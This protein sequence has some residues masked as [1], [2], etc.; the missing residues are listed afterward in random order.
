MNKVRRILSLVLIAVMMCSALCTNAG[1]YSDCAH[2]REEEYMVAGNVFDENGKCIQQGYFVRVCLDCETQLTEPDGTIQRVESEHQFKDGKCEVCGYTTAC[3]HTNSD[4]SFTGN[5]STTDDGVW[6]KGYFIKYCNDCG[7]EISERK[8]DERLTKHQFD[9]NGKCKKC[10]YVVK[11]EERAAWVYNTDGQN[12]YLREK[13]ATG[14]TKVLARM[15]EGSQITVIGKSKTNGFYKVRY[16]NITGYAHSDYITF[17]KQTKQTTTSK[18]IFG[19]PFKGTARITVLEYYY[20][21]KSGGVHPT[22]GLGGIRGAIDFAVAGSAL[23]TKSGTVVEAKNGYNG[24]WG[25][26]IV[27]RHTDGGTYSFYAHLAKI[28]VSVNQKVKQGQAIGIIGSTGQ[29][30]GTHLHFEVWQSN[31]QTMY[32]IDLFKNCKDRLRFDADIVSG[33]ANST[34]IRNWIKSNYKLSGGVYVPKTSTSSSSKTTTTSSSKQTTTQS[35][36]A[37]NK[38]VSFV[39]ANLTAW[40]GALD[41]KFQAAN[42]V[43]EVVN[44]VNIRSGIQKVLGTGIVAAWTVSPSLLFKAFDE[45]V[46]IGIAS[47][48]VTNEY[49]TRANVAHNSFLALVNKGIK[50]AAQAEK[51][52]ELYKESIAC[53]SAVIDA[54]YSTIC[55]YTKGSTYTKKML[56][57]FFLSVADTVI[58]DLG[59]LTKI[60]NATMTTAELLETVESG[61]SGLKSYRETVNQWNR[62]WSKL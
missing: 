4:E 47:F 50:T 7:R 60:T 25:N 37:T 42:S 33:G 35:A 19:L 62:I 23:A 22:K 57:T 53:Y 28:S 59:A 48:G 24:G 45:D 12:L 18:E 40:K 34:S 13:P 3:E 9:G 26:Y 32:T 51:A 15:P 38:K 20:G 6:R 1:A 49:L 52:F 44:S 46:V 14:T 41:S 10:G 31:K 11:E 58:P 2:T 21:K 27:I 29:S 43:F 8:Y 56:N 16:K 39:N 17:S 55:E 5:I 54:H 30:T 36:T 61:W